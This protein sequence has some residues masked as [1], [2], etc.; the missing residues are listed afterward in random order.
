MERAQFRQLADQHRADGRAHTGG[1]LQQLLPARQRRVGVDL[2]LDHLLHVFEFFVQV[3]DVAVDDLAHHGH[4]GVFELIAQAGT[5]ADQLPSEHDQLLQHVQHLTALTDDAGGIGLA[6]LGQHLRIHLIV[7]GTNPPAFGEVAHIG[8]IE[9]DG[10]VTLI[11]QGEKHRAFIT[12]GGFQNDAIRPQRTKELQQLL[13]PVK[14][15]GNTQTFIVRQ[16]IDIQVGLGDINADASWSKHDFE[17][18]LVKKSERRRGVSHPSTRSTVRG[19]PTG[20]FD[21]LPLTK[22]F[23]STKPRPEHRSILITLQSEEEPD[24]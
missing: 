11:H 2:V 17:P 16:S 9:H 20:E 12:A 1:L 13:M 4:I 5:L 14:G 8:G 7:L 10:G 3:L 15:V 19:K 18:L 21:R 24:A 6:K 23:T 22:R